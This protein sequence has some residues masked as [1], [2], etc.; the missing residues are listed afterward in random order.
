MGILVTVFKNKKTKN[1][2][3]KIRAEFRSPQQLHHWIHNQNEADTLQ[4]RQAHRSQ[5]QARALIHE[6][7]KVP[8]GYCRTHH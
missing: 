4:H 7:S 1:L 3:D 6:Q 5:S 8:A 2:S